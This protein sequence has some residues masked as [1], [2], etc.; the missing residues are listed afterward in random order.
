VVYA[1]LDFEAVCGFAFRYRHHPCISNED[2]EF[3]VPIG[4]EVA[5]ADLNTSE[6]FKVQYHL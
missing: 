4:Q 6:G 2:V 1:E 5:S 3:L